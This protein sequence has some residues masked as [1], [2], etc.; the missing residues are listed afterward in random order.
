MECTSK[1][2]AFPIGASLGTPWELHLLLGTSWQLWV[3]VANAHG[4]GGGGHVRSMLGWE[5]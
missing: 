2:Q 1:I 5:F 4:L 3:L